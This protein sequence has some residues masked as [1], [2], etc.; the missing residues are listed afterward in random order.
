VGIGTKFAFLPLTL[1]GLLL[2]ALLIHRS[3]PDSRRVDLSTEHRSMP[4]PMAPNGPGGGEGG[5]RGEACCAPTPG[6]HTPG[7]PGTQGTQGRDTIR[8]R[9]PK[10]WDVHVPPGS[11]LDSLARALARDVAILPPRDLEDQTPLPL[12]FRVYL[13]KKNPNLPATGPYQYPRSAPALLRWM[14]QHADS[15]KL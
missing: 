5:S 15:V 11:R 13:R 4:P 7:R 2:S 1:G 6:T 14:V 10:D 12:W 9:Y 8:A 3:L